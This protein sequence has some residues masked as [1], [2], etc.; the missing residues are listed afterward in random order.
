MQCNKMVEIYGP[1]IINMLKDHVDSDK[2]CSKMALCSSND[3]FAMSFK[4]RRVLRSVNELTKK[5]TWGKLF[6]C[7]NEEVMKLCNVSI[8][9]REIRNWKLN[10]NSQIVRFELGWEAVR[11]L[12]KKWWSWIDIVNRADDTKLQIGGKHKKWKRRVMH[13]GSIRFLEILAVAN[14]LFHVI[15][16][17]SLY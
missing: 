1:S 10:D 15:Y 12:P 8:W 4:T 9:T 17:W 6:V 16:R 2:M 11:R 7:K 14:D 3:Y 13:Y 5:C